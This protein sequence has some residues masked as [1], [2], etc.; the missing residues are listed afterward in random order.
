MSTT[1]GIGFLIGLGACFTPPMDT[2]V[3]RASFD[4]GCPADRLQVVELDAHV[5]GVSGCGKRA[6]YVW[7]ARNSYEG[8]WIANSPQQPT[9]V[10][11]QEGAKQ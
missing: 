4:L 11:T 6:T 9:A 2:L 1:A 7:Q 8:D 10:Q 5:R 3:S